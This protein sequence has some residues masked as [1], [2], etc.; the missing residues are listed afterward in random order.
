MEAS[1]LPSKVL[2]DLCQQVVVAVVKRDDPA[3][4]TLR[5]EFAVPFLN[6]WVVVLDDK[7][8]TLASWDR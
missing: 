4:A 2:R 8:E 5:Q 3:C 7:G 6:S 1:L